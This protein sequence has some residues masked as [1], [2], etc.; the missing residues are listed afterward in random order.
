MCT[1]TQTFHKRSWLV[2]GAPKG[3]HR[4]VSLR[5]VGFPP[6]GSHTCW[7][8]WSVFQ[9]G[10]IGSIAPAASSRRSRRS[11]Y[12]ARFRLGR[13]GGISEG[14]IPTL[15]PPTQPL[16]TSPARC[17]VNQ[18]GTPKP[19]GHSCLPIAS[20]S[21]ISSTF[22]SLSKVLFIFPSR[23]LF[24]IGLLPVFSLRRNLPPN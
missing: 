1:P 3:S 16:L 19:A 2:D 4:S 11:P 7:T 5:L 6:T 10:P 13:V 12:G 18:N 14:T 21:T 22:N 15:L 9:D 8:P 24:A 17:R 20:P 23:Y